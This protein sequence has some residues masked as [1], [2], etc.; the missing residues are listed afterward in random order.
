S[1]APIHLEACR[2]WLPAA[3][4]TWRSLAPEALVPIQQSFPS[5]GMI[6][7]G[8]KGGAVVDYG[9]LPLTYTAIDVLCTGES[10]SK[11]S[12]WAH[13]RIKREAFDI[14]GGWVNSSLG[15]R[16]ALQC[17]P[18]LKTLKR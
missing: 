13:L 4:K 5:D 2:L 10:G 16:T 7:A 8:E 3:R 1:T 12:L 6:A 18:F 9:L 17:E 14:S 11:F 15:S